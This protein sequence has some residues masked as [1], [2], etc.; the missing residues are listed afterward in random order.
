MP[1]VI[2]LTGNIACGKTSVGQ[3]LLDQGAERYIDADA[4]VHHLYERGQPIAL[5]VAE[6]FGPSVLASDGSVERKALGA[7]VFQDPA[8]LRKLEQIVHPVVGEA[9]LQEL[10]SVSA[11]GIAIIDAVKL[12]EGGSA[13]LCQ[14]KWLVVCPEEQE[15]A[16]LMARNKLSAAEAHARIQ[17]QPPITPKLALVDEVID[18]GGTLAETRQ[19]VA[20]AFERFIRKF[21]A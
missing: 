21:P 1:R 7:I 10:A 18:N 15:L 20:A 17:A 12:L 5:K 6:R 14:S 19:Q 8:A 13:R 16:R 11:T 4:V 9:L 3:M 2:G